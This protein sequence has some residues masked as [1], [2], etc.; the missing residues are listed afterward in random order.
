MSGPFLTL[1]NGAAAALAEVPVAPMGAFR[2]TLIAEGRT[3]GRLVALFPWGEGAKRRLLALLASES[4]GCF[5]VLAGELGAADRY[6]ALTAEWPQAQAFERHLWENWGIAPEGHPWLKPLAFPGARA[7]RSFPGAYPYFAAAGGDLHEVAVGPVHAGV[8]EPGH[9]RFQCRGEEVLHLE[10][11]LGY[12]HRGLEGLLREA[13]YAKRLALVESLAGDTAV[14]HATCWA[15]VEEALGGAS[16]APRGQG[17]RAVALELERLANHAGDLGA[18]AGDVGF[19]PA[20]SYLGGLRGDFLNLTAALSGSRFGRG[21]V[22]PGGVRAGLGGA[23]TDEVA[24]ALEPL[25]VAFREYAGLL[26]DA[27]SVEARFEGTGAV[28]RETAEALGLV[29]V[30]ARASGCDLDVRRDFPAG[31]YRFAQ[32]S[33]RVLQTG[34]VYARAMVRRLEAEE[35][36]RF[37]AECLPAL[38]AGE[39]SRP[40]APPRPARLAAAAVEGWR[41]EIVHAA[42][43][44]PDGKI[45]ALQLVDPS[46]HNWMGLALALRGQAISDF[47]LCNKS[48]NLSYAGHDR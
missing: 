12:Q 18:L 38:P 46:F 30:A 42:V 10:I 11:Q 40:A 39:G 16:T 44:G 22:V 21:L 31:Y 45:A 26:F 8:I 14:G 36:L 23:A 1:A 3:R 24:R 20:A 47:P 6:A 27:A 29:G 7:D 41:G 28:E 4:Q 43:T 32:V 34:D 19:L 2:E 17:M 48:F 15:M 35:S 25:G 9:F 33:T 13:P 5:L 37:L